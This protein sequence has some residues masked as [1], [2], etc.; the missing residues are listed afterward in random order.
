MA[1]RFTIIWAFC[2]MR[3]RTPHPSLVI[4]I[5]DLGLGAK[6]AIW[7]DFWRG[8]RKAIFVSN[9]EQGEFGP[10]LFR[11]ACNLGL[12][13]WFQS[14]AIVHTAPAGRL[15]GSRSRSENIPR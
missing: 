11:A 12:E 9:F 8:G 10:N 4:E 15:I 3:Y 5:N 2:R 1:L 13:G 7:R 14:G 6:R